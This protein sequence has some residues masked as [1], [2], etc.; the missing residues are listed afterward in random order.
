MRI[1]FGLFILSSLLAGCNYNHTKGDAPSMTG[2]GSAGVNTLSLDFLSVQN[3][4]LSGRCLTCHSSAAGNQ[5]G[6]NLDSYQQVRAT[7]NK[8]YYRVIE[9][10]DM[11]PTALTT[12][13]FDLLK[14][15]IEAGAPQKNTGRSSG[16]ISGPINWDVIKKQVLATS[17]LDCHSGA[18][19][20][21][22][23]NLES[24]ENVRK[25]INGIFESTIVKQTMPLEPYPAMSDSAKQ[26]LM[27]WISQGMPN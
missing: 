22:Q 23:L 16:V 6:L 18:N 13:Q 1:V 17:C 20:D 10:K 9:K 19:P 5:G 26:A 14:A 2:S 24:I 25:N 12:A 11:P 3:S 27:K 4:V 8:I 15:W 7:L 21:G